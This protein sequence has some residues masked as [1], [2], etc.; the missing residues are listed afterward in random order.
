MTGAG[1]EAWAVVVGALVAC[2]VLTLVGPRGRS[3]RAVAG[4]GDESGRCSAPVPGWLGK[5][6]PGW[7]VGQRPRDARPSVQVLV[8]QV[9]GLLRGGASPGQAWQLLGDVRVD[10]IGTPDEDD[11]LVLVAGGSG[12]AGEVDRAR[13]QVAAIVAACR[14]A[15]EV[16]APLASVLDAIVAALVSAAR[17]ESERA[18]ALAGPRSTAR[19]LAWLPG[20]GAV[21]G[22]ALGADPLGLFVAGG[23][24]AAAPMAGLVLV[25]VGHRWTTRLVARARAAGE[26]P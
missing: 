24:G 13:R 1:I 15:G 20:I 19:V 12:R 4:R 10:R 11:L 2:A 25:G 21:L 22:M 5:V 17:A 18:A 6:A 23:L 3:V 9:A 14:L 7:L 16:G 8:T 26:P